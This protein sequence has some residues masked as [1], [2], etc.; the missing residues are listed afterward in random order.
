[1]CFMCYFLSHLLEKAL[2]IRVPVAAL[3]RLPRILLLLLFYDRGFSTSRHSMGVRRAHEA[4]RLLA[5]RVLQQPL[6]LGI[7]PFKEKGGQLPHVAQANPAQA[8]APSCAGSKAEAEHAEEKHGQDCRLHLRQWHCGMWQAADAIVA[9][10]ALLTVRASE[11]RPAHA[12][13]RYV[14]ADSPV[15]TIP[16]ARPRP[17]RWIPRVARDAAFA[18]PAREER[19]AVAHG[20][21]AGVAAKA[22]RLAG[23]WRLCLLLMLLSAKGLK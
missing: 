15:E 20:N 18:P 4:M 17:A 23:E 14:I 16:T 3:P 9:S 8:D 5:S 11:V 7:G 19:P 12:A 2:K 21:A 10:G 13:A 6:R 22:E 1:M